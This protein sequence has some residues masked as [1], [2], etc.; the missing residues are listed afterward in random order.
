MSTGV[1]PTGGGAVSPAARAGAQ[2][3]TTT[4][5]RPAGPGTAG[6]AVP[7]W[8]RRRR[9]PAR[10]L[11]VPSRFAMW[12]GIVLALGAYT[13]FGLVP[14]AG[15]ALISLTDYQDFPGETFNFIGLSNYT[16]M[17]TNERPG[18]VA[19]IKAT[20]I[21]VLAVTI[22]QNTIA[23]MLA[24]RLSGPG[25]TTAILRVVV[26][27]P[28]VLGV[29]VGGLIWILIFSPS[30]GPGASLWSLF[31]ANSSFFGS[32]SLAMPLVIFVQIW[33][34]LGFASLVFI[35]GLRAIDPAIYEAAAIDGIGRWQRFR[36][37]TWPLMAPSVTAN[38]L[39]AVVGSMTVFQTIYVLTDGQ[40]G[41]MT[42]G[43][44]SF[45]TAFGTGSNLA[46]G[47]AVSTS[48]FLVTLVVAV[49]LMWVL[50]WRERRLLG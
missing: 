15:N 1:N 38:V 35:G 42:L 36:R 11:S 4:A 33:L 20:I 40:N 32:P 44:L 39:L 21:F 47:A 7:G 28:A 45:N 46:F 22:L 18:V 27:L 13:L 9:R 26:F 16:D 43:M 41:T 34:S 30:G 8:L 12:A 19:A 48:L 49:P 24:H 37:I 2:H 10:L 50:R 3:G 5:E 25:R 17:F 6:A 29:V 14:T 23:M 31:G